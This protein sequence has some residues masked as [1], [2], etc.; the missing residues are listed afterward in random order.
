MKVQVLIT[1]LNKVIPKR[2]IFNFKVEDGVKDPTIL[3]KLSNHAIKEVK[4]I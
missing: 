4:L 2:F 1:F 3:H